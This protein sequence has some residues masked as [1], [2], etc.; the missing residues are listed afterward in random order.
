MDSYCQKLSISA[1]YSV[2]IKCQ[3]MSLLTMT[4]EQFQTLLD[5]MRQ[6]MMAGA[7]NQVIPTNSGNFAKWCIKF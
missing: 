6:M 3:K 1:E 2:R 5:N 4:D 7:D